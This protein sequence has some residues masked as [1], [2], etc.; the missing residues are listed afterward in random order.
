MNRAEFVSVAIPMVL[1]F[2]L[3]IAI[4]ESVSLASVE[5][6]DFFLVMAMALSVSAEVVTAFALDFATA[7]AVSVSVAAVM[8]PDRA[9][10]PCAAAYAWY[11][12]DIAKPPYG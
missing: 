2:A 3:P 10:A 7:R 9:P 6:F 12:Q 4:A 1:R 11:H 5:T 8:M